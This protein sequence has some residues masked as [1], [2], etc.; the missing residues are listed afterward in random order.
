MFPT[1]RCVLCM[2]IETNKKKLKGEIRKIKL[3]K[4]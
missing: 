3:D 4:S 2:Y 1:V